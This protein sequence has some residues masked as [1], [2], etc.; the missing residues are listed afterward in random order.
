MGEVYQANAEV[1]ELC[2]YKRCTLAILTILLECNVM[3]V[4]LSI[5]DLCVTSR[6]DAV[7]RDVCA[8]ME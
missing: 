8:Q 3:S 2:L 6:S 1:S 5:E 4:A 7:L